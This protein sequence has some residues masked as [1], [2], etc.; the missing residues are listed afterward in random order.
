MKCLTLET[1]F[2]I[3]VTVG[4][5]LVEALKVRP[6]E[7]PQLANRAGRAEQTGSGAASPS[8]Q[9]LARNGCPSISA[10]YLRVVWKSAL[11]NPRAWM[12][13]SLQNL[14]GVNL[15]KGGLQWVL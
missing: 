10:N 6:Y 3:Y 8:G 9:E 2:A 7:L 13:A 1:L 12:F 5:F 11:L 14:F 15:T 4:K